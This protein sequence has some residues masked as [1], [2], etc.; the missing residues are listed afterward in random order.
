MEN[1][2][3]MTV[4]ATV[5]S[6]KDDLLVSVKNIRNIFS[7]FLYSSQIVTTQGN[8]SSYLAPL[9]KDSFTGVVKEVEEKL[10]VVNQ[11]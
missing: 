4:E 1:N 10:K 9:N 5:V 7:A 8:F 6:E 11:T 2:M 3:T